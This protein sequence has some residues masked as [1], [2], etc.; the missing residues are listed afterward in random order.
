MVTET[1]DVLSSSKL[2]LRK[3]L[4]FLKDFFFLD[5]RAAEAGV[6]RFCGLWNDVEGV[7]TLMGDFVG[8]MCRGDPR[9]W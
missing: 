9:G 7:E 3:A 6:F 1:G 2:C 4:D 8:V 5:V